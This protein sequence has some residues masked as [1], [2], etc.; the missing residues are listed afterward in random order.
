MKLV[1]IFIIGIWF[2]LFFGI[3]WTK[4]LSIN[5]PSA[6]FHMTEIDNNT[7]SW[8]EFDDDPKFFKDGQEISVIVRKENQ[9][10]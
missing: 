10:D 4:T 5:K 3:C 8:I 1:L 9:N 7:E 2:G 6:I